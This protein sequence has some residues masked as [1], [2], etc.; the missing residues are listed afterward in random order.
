MTPQIEDW[1]AMVD[2]VMI[3]TAYNGEVFNIVVAD[4]PE[5]KS[6]PL[7]AGQYLLPA[8]DGQT[9]VAVKRSHGYVRR[10]SGNL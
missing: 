6:G 3:D 8:N 7:V 4:I 2:S 1:R 5:K 9:T 10:R